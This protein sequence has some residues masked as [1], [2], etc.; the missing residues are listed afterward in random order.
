[1]SSKLKRKVLQVSVFPWRQIS[2]QQPGGP[3]NRRGGDVERDQDD[4]HDGEEAGPEA[5][6]G[7]AHHLPQGH[8]DG[9]SGHWGSWPRLLH[10]QVPLDGVME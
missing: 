10:L 2:R 1:M 9:D 6:P 5:G 4:Q 7:G 8:Q 3:A